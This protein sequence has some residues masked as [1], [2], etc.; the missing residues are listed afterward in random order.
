MNTLIEKDKELQE[1]LDIIPETGKGTKLRRL[2][3]KAIEKAYKSG[4]V[5]FN[6]LDNTMVEEKHF[7]RCKWR[8]A[9]FNFE[10][11]ENATLVRTYLNEN[12][13]VD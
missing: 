7:N 12:G 3:G 8:T 11:G 2:V 10:T 5:R 13:Y 4:M 6:A 1:L 9:E